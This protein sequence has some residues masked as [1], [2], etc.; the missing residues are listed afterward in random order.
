[1]NEEYRISKRDVR[2]A[3]SASA[4]D[5]DAVAVVQREVRPQ[6]HDHRRH[7][8][9]HHADHRYDRVDDRLAEA[10]EEERDGEESEG[11]ED[12]V[13]RAE[14]LPEGEPGRLAPHLHQAEVAASQG[15]WMQS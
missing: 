6:L 2:R 12:L 5:Y 10:V 13:G 11:G 3:F 8:H 9:H 14:Q 7:R 15:N 4:D 1:M